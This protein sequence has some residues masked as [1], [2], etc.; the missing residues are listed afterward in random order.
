MLGSKARNHD[1]KRFFSICA[2]AFFILTIAMV[3]TATAKSLYVLA[4]HHAR[5][6]DAWNI[7]PGGTVTKQGT[8]NLMYARYPAGVAIHEDYT[9]TPPT[10]TLFISSESNNLEVVD[11]TTFASLGQLAGVQFAGLAVDDKNDIL[12]AM[13][14]W[15]NDLYAYDFSRTGSTWTLTLKAGF[16]KALPGL[17][18]HYGMGIAL[19]EL[20][21]PPILWVADSGNMMVRAYDTTTWA[22]DTSLSFS[23]ASTGKGAIGIRNGPGKR[24]H[25]LGFYDLGRRRTTQCWVIR[26]LQVRP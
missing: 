10:A 16:P 19:D 11:A 21:D 4:S 14:R 12:Y 15:P 9:T 3:G 23:T 25:L 2:V 22:E 24:H 7:N 8:Y 18:R 5:Q 6:F 20:S 1:L 26:P 13:R 17:Y